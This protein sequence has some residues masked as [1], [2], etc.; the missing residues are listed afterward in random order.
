MGDLLEVPLGPR[1]VLGVVWGPGEGGYEPSRI[2]A[3]ARVLDVPP[4][5]GEMRQFLSRVAD[6]TLT[7]PSM[8]LRLATRAPGLGEGPATRRVHRRGPGE[9]PRMTPARARVLGALEGGGVFTLGELAEAAG[10]SAGVV[11]GLVP[12]GAVL[13]EEA[14]RDL[15]YPALD[16]ARP[17]PALTE[18]QAAAARSLRAGIASRAYGATLLKGVTGSGKTEVYLEAVAECLARG[19]QALVLLPEIA[20]TAEFIAR[21]EAR[22]GR[23][24]G[25]VALGRDLDGPAA[26]LAHGGRGAARASSWAR[27]RRSTCHS[28]TSA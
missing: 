25:G 17:G 6:Y 12:S 3:A 24:T 2:K 19:R 13:E 8:M 15:P 23:A 4:M 5:R 18:E 28:A 14:P 27:A 11:K 21:V 20:L 26:L 10:V 9:P 16:P 22:F 1:R 7:D